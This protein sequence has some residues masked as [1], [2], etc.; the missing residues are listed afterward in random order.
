VDDGPVLAERGVLAVADEVWNLAVRR[1][2]V[3]RPLAE[4]GVVGHA[5]ADAAAVELGV[6][7]RQVYLMVRRWRAG[8]GVVSDLVPGR[9]SG[10]RGR[11]HLPDAVET[12]VRELL[13][14]R[15]LTRQKR[16][17]AAVHRELARICRSRGW[18]VPSR[19]TL[20]RRVAMLDPVRAATSRQGPDAARV[21]R[22]AGGTPPGVTGLLEQVQID[23][24]VVDLIVVDEQHRLPIGRP[25]ITV[26]IDVASRCIV[27]LVVT[28][29]AP[30]A[31]SVGLYPT[32]AGRSCP[33][34]SLSQGEGGWRSPTVTR[35][36]SAAFGT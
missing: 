25:Y 24:T 10:G 7:R 4:G 31:L 22:S 17:L 36:A 8:D 15:F 35:R 14:T 29:E 21:L 16:S 5:A 30:S 19:G 3:I 27:G 20:A 34:G 33:A 23:H 12:V 9:S 2:A 32:S 18:R 28:L 26:G 11:G 6:S 1:A 13:R